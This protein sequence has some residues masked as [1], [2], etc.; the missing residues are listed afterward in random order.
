MD[1][2]LITF[3]LYEVKYIK[4][5]LFLT[6]LNVAVGNFKMTDVACLGLPCLL[7]LLGDSVGGCAGFRLF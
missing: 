7:F 6:F 2:M 5:H 3:W 4:C 1:D